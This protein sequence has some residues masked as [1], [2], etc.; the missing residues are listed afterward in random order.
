MAT[1][2]RPDPRRRKQNHPH[3]T[4]LDVPPGAKHGGYLAGQLYGCYTHR[5]GATK[6]CVASI[7]DDALECPFCRVGDESV[8]KGYVPLW[9][10]DWTLRHVLI[11]EQYLATV[12]AIP[13]HAK[14]T[15]SK[16]KNPIS[17]VI[18]REEPLL[19]RDLP[20]K[21][22]WKDEVCM[23]AVCLTLWKNAPLTKWCL[24]NQ[25]LALAAAVPP[26]P[27]PP[28]APKV[29]AYKAPVT[30]GATEVEHDALKNRILGRAKNLK[31]STN[32]QHE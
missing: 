9:D 13:F 3:S 28:P 26:T 17:P 27:L 11:S 12:D 24:D 23:L 31:P 4:T 15:V 29:T 30:D 32:G 16:H 18:I 8:W 7:T 20:N 25:P 5:S 19:T 1:G 6:P 2:K 14:I 21:S 10:R 22:P